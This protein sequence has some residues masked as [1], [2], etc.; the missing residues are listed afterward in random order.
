M[1]IVINDIDEGFFVD[2]WE[3]SKAIDFAS[4]LGITPKYLLTTHKHWDHS[5]GNSDM[6]AAFPDIRVFWSK[7]LYRSCLLKCNW[8]WWNIDACNY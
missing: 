4:T 2:V 1:L 5:N 3:S 7:G 6:V 8:N